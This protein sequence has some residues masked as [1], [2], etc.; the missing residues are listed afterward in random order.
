M[1]VEL[2]SAEDLSLEIAPYF[3]DL[4]QRL[5]VGDPLASVAFGR[6][7]HW[8]YWPDPVCAIGSP[9][10][11]AAAAELLCRRMCDVA[12]IADGMRILDVGCGIGGAL[13]S[14]NERFDDLELVGL[15]LDNRQLERAAATIHPRQGNRIQWVQGD[16]CQMEFR[17]VPFD[18]VLAVECIF[19]FRSREAFFERAAAAL[20]PGGRLTLSDFVPRPLSPDELR[21]LEIVSRAAAQHTFGR[22]GLDFPVAR[23]R[24]LAQQHR[25]ALRTT[26]NIT[27]QTMPTYPFL[28]ADVRA[29]RD[30]VGARHHLKA[31]SRL[32]SAC[33]RGLLEYA[34]LSFSS[35]A[36]DRNR[37]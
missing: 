35:A 28:R 30:V 5:A 14:L 10:D 23:Y 6:H 36:D 9:E 19:H 34:I 18:V 24:E 22:V 27:R 17:S 7:V 13:A 31:I 11:Y 37:L 16:A 15:N 20:K 12:G 25:L 8:G 26:D 4:L 3:E 29:R 2:S 1:S 21:Q 32:E 33:Q